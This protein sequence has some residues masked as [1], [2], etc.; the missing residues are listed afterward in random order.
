MTTHSH[1]DI[2]LAD[3]VKEHAKRLAEEAAKDPSDLVN[4][5]LRDAFALREELREEVRLGRE[6]VAA[7]RV[8]EHARVRDWLRSWGTDDA[9]RPRPK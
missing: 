4:D 3:D 9:P 5:V 1:D 2:V 6:D 7:G 8:V